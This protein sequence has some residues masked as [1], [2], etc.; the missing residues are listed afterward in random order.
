MLGIKD[1]NRDS[2]VTRDVS[3][4]SKL[5]GVSG[6]DIAVEIFQRNCAELAY[7]KWSSAYT[8]AAPLGRHQLCQPIQG[9]YI[10]CV[11]THLR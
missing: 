7:S 11:P 1:K 4:T 5:S 9:E 8:S 10:V 3:V 2:K 6:V